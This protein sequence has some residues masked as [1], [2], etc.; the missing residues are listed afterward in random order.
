MADRNLSRAHVGL[1]LAS[2]LIVLLASGVAI[3]RLGDDDRGV[4]TS[5][6]GAT[7]STAGLGSGA[8][9]SGPATGAASG[10][11]GGAAAG[12]EQAAGAADA[13]ATAAGPTTRSDRPDRSTP[14][15]K[16]A[17][18]DRAGSDTASDS[19]P[20]TASAESGPAGSGNTAGESAGS[21]TGGSQPG[22]PG[23]Q[24][25]P[26][27]QPQPQPQPSQD[28]PEQKPL[29]AASASVGQGA[30]GGVVG[31]TLDGGSPELDVTVG[32]DQVVGNHPPSQGTGVNLGGRFLNP[33]PTVPLPPG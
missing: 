11:A 9:D 19:P 5:A 3:S 1:A 23:G 6:S 27:A 4:S 31:V 10:A 17:S 21:S 7:S 2:A 18:S 14:Q 15:G 13:L 20:R 32:T 28:R 33:P 30:Q 25:G 26:E 22:G 16:S 29:L 12:T 8:V 24:G